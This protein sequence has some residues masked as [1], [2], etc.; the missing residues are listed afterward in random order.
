MSYKGIVVKVGQFWY[1]TSNPRRQFKITEIVASTSFGAYRDAI[2]DIYEDE[3][4]VGNTRF[5]G[6][7]FDL[8]PFAWSFGWMCDNLNAKEKLFSVV[9]RKSLRKR[10]RQQIAASS[11]T[12]KS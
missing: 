5:G 7:D 9:S 11:L 10:L 8:A 3:R 1:H 4:Y 6:L 12:E 2:A